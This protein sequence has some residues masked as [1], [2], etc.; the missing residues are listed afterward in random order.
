MQIKA[1]PLGS[2]TPSLAKSDP[3]VKLAPDHKAKPD[4]WDDAK[5]KVP[6]KKADDPSAADIAPSARLPLF[7]D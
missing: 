1:T 2:A 7:I 3:K 5:Q 6:A 4:H